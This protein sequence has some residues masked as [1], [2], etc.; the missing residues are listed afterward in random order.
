MEKSVKV[1]FLVGCGKG[2]K[3]EFLEKRTKHVELYVG[4]THN[5]AFI[6]RLLCYC[7]IIMLMCYNT[8]NVNAVII[9]IT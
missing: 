9:I 8:P 4:D 1:S 5:T 7:N 6:R 3:M 2:W